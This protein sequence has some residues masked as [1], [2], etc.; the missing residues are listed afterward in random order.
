M[1][2]FTFFYKIRKPRPIFPRDFICSLFQVCRYCLHV[3]GFWPLVVETKSI[4][5]EPLNL[6]LFNIPDSLAEKGN[7]GSLQCFLSRFISVLSFCFIF[8]FLLCHFL[9][10]LSSTPRNP[11][12][13]LRSSFPRHPGSL[14]GTILTL[15]PFKNPACS[16]LN[17]FNWSMLNAGV[18]SI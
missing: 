9:L 17:T 12:G 13:K 10:F 16:P 4:T 3:M 11:E 15:D 1:L 2:Q 5:Q 8:L 18:P 7:N 14:G 6:Q